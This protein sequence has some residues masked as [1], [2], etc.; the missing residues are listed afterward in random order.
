MATT[1][2]IIQKDAQGNVMEV[3]IGANAT[4]IT[5]DSTH[6]FVTDAEKESWS[7]KANT[8]TYTTTISTTWTGSNAPYTQTI[9]VSGILATDNPVVDCVLS[10]ATATALLQEK[11]W[12]CISRITTAANS[13]TVTCNKKKPVTAIPIQLKVVR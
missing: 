7:A 12:N 9:A 4:N 11:A 2:K 8:K 5:Q 1:K 10:A 6:R 13:I 3:D